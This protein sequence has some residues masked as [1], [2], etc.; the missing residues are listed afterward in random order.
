VRLYPDYGLFLTGQGYTREARYCFY[1]FPFNHFMLVGHDQFTTMKNKVFD[2]VEYAVSLDF[3]SRILAD[4]LSLSPP[5][6]ANCVRAEL[7]RDPSNTQI[8]QLSETLALGVEATLGKLQRGLHDEFVPFVI[9]RVFSVQ[10]LE[11]EWSELKQIPLG[12]VKPTPSNAAVDEQAP[13]MH[14]VVRRSDVESCMI[15]PTLKPLQL[16]NSDPETS[17]RFQ[18]NVTLSFQGYD[19]DSREL[20]QIEEVRKFV[21]RL[22]ATWYFWFFFMTKDVDISPLAAITLS[23]CRY[24]R[25]RAGRS[26]PVVADAKRL[27]KYHFTALRYVC[28][29]CNLSDEQTESAVQDVID[30]FM[31][32]DFVSGCDTPQLAVDSAKTGTVLRYQMDGIGE[33]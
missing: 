27:F 8:I 3:D 4:I 18:N 11:G 15:E 5:S 16:L 33:G 17:L 30:Y 14:I 13:F 26:R 19:Q 31:R 9:H 10:V 20:F 23:L 12:E 2:G 32:V 7:G 6:I 1:E 25:S 28:K 29:T 24:K 21:E 22:N